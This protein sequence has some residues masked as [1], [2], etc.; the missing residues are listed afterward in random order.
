VFETPSLLEAVAVLAIEAGKRILEVYHTDF[1][2]Q[3]KEDHSPLTLADLAAHACIQQGLQKIGHPDWPLLSEE[4]VEIPF[5]ERSGWTT[6]WLVDPLDGTK[7]FIHRRPEFTVNIA[8]IQDGYPV[9]GVVYVPVTG[10]CYCAMEGQGAFRMDEHGERTLLEVHRKVR[11]PIQVVGS[12]SHGSPEMENFLKR[13]PPHHLVSQG[14]SLKF[15]LVAEGKADLYPRIGPTSEW[16][17]AA[18]QCVVE[19]AG[20]V[21]VDLL[22]NRLRYNQKVSLLNPF[23]MVYA[24]SS[25]DWLSL[26]QEDGLSVSKPC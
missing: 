17:T 16:D 23:F 10:I 11:D 5:A 8:L 19:Q 4:S 12:R 25:V 3:T 2:V 14:S 15:C 22:G 6:Y 13:L 9:L 21:V 7:E 18:A 20:G 26:A 1:S 24:D